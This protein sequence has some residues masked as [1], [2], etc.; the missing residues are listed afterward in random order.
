VVVEGVVLVGHPP[1]AVVGGAERL[2]GAG[3]GLLGQKA[4]RVDHGRESM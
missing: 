3:V 4:A 1:G 2:V